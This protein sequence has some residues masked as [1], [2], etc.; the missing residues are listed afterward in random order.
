MI[1]I[2]KRHLNKY[3]FIEIDDKSTTFQISIRYHH[4]RYEL[5]RLIEKIRLMFDV[6][7]QL[8]CKLCTEWF[9]REKKKIC[10]D[11]IEFLK[12]YR[13]EM[14]MVNWVVVDEK[15]DRMTIE[16][17]ISALST[18]YSVNKVMTKFCE[19]WFE[20]KIIEKSSKNMG[21]Y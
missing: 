9:E 7:Y 6:D 16:E 4:Y 18:H 19:E 20:N 3:Y 2:I 8:A 17:L 10:R 15:G 12:P 13:V 14:T 21:I 11:V 5:Y 1:D